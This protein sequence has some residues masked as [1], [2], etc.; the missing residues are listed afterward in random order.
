MQDLHS[1]K[2]I[3]MGFEREGLYYLDQAKKGTC[4]SV[5]TLASGLWHQRLGHPSKKVFQLF[6][7]SKTKSCDTNKCLICPLAKQTRS[8]FPLSSISSKVCFDLIHVD[9]WGGYKIASLSSAKYFLT[10]VDDITRSTWVYLME[11]K[12]DTRDL[13][14]KFIHMVET[15]FNS[16]VKIVRSDNGPEFKL[17]N[18]YALKG[19]VHQSSCVNTP[20]QNGVAKCK[21][22]Y[23]LNVAQALLIQAGLHKQFL[24]DAILATTYLINRT[25]THLLHG[26]TPYKKLF[27]QAPNY[28]HL[29][30]FGCLCFVSTHAQKPWIPLWSERV[31]CV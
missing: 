25:P 13:L 20:Q 18:F 6:P 2:I 31:S 22:R 12:S 21:H 16:K 15:Q 17:E 10:I 14:V 1:G 27:H 11:H 24:G 29:R 3:G 9:I 26:K 4:N 19:I 7:F 28:S 8:P 30:V 5:Q 23:L